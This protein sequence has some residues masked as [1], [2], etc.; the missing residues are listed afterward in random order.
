MCASSAIAWVARLGDY[1]KGC[2][3]GDDFIRVDSV[4]GAL[5]F[6]AQ[7]AGGVEGRIGMIK[8]GVITVVMLFGIFV[9]YCIFMSKDLSRRTIAGAERF[10]ANP[11]NVDYVVYY[12]GEKGAIPAEIG[13]ECRTQKLTQQI[14]GAPYIISA[15]CPGGRDYELNFVSPKYVTIGNSDRK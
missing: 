5:V 14:S 10:M 8:Y 15:Q 2:L 7:S 13:P 12:K 4:R 1:A 9:I 3:W 6:R 11:N